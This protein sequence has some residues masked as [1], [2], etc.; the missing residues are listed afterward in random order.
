MSETTGAAR[1]RPRTFDRAAALATA[2]RLF[3]ERGYEATSIGDLAEAM[4]IRS[5][6]LYAAFGDKR[7]LF[8][9]V[10]DA[11]GRSPEGAF[12]GAALAEE[13]TAY[14][15][16]ARILREAAAVY[17]DPAHPPGCLTISAATNVNP[18]DA[19]V[20][21]FLR[22]LRAANLDAFTARLAAARRDG[23]LPPDADPRA[24]AGYLATL[25]QGL[26]QRAQ[27]GADADEL[28]A[29]VELAL[30]AW[31]GGPAREA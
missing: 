26:S 5:G 9:E 25:I 29:V 6:S 7:S 11:Y 2:I 16:F 28:R 31:P 19:E 1:G 4:E 22:E 13:P 12:I 21:A 14:R 27:D 30:A 8:R 17:P 18:R 10:V 15:A 3:W 20:R 24:L 23:E